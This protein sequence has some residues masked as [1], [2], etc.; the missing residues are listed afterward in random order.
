MLNAVL[1]VCVHCFVVLGCSVTRRYVDVCYCD[2]FCVCDVYLDLLKFDV[3]CINGLR[4][5]CCSEC[6]VVF[7]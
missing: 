5:V 4:Y 3:M 2:M 6:Y 1:Y 7:N